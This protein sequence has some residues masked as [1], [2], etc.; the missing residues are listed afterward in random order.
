MPILRRQGHLR[1]EK[2]QETAA[3]LLLLV[4]S[5]SSL[6]VR[7]ALDGSGESFSSLGS[8]GDRLLIPDWR[9]TRELREGVNAGLV[10]MT[11]WEQ[12]TLEKVALDIG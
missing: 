5:V 9:D 3:F 1:Q 12:I 10:R 6:I 8:S 4:K 7:R 11:P 2:S